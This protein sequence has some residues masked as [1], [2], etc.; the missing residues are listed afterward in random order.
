VVSVR[1]A[2]TGAVVVA[3]VTHSTDNTVTVAVNGTAPANN[4][5]KVVVI[6]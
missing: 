6:G 5:L 2:S 1:E 3:A 4:A